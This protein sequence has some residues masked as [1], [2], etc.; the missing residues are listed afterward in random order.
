MN[1]MVRKEFP[2]FKPLV[3]FHISISFILGDY[4][5]TL[6]PKKFIF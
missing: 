6:S 5:N 2:F 4:A 1:T 3:E